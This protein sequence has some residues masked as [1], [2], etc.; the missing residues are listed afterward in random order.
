MLP[1][2]FS[3]TVENLSR[4]R[5]FF[6]ARRNPGPNRRLVF[7]NIK[8]IHERAEPRPCFYSDYRARNSPGPA[9]FGRPA[10]I[11]AAGLVMMIAAAAPFV[12][13]FVL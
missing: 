8:R 5:I 7:G 9:R 12:P 1:F 4:L 11:S 2:A 3:A 13:R 10:T 6:G